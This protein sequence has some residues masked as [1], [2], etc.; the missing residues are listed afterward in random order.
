M[1]LGYR[2]EEDFLIGDK[3]QTVSV[4]SF[5]APGQKQAYFF[6]LEGTRK[7]QFSYWPGPDNYQGKKAFFVVFE[8]IPK[9]NDPSLAAKYTEALSP[10]F[11]S[12]KFLGMRPLFEANGST[13]KGMLL[14]EGNGYKGRMPSDPSLY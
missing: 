13:A 9:L 3:Y 12:V 6:N 2:P 14:F 8:N 4:L 11:D 5:Y 1:E 10:Y 7:N